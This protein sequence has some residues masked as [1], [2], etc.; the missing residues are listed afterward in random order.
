MLPLRLHD[1]VVWCNRRYCA[2]LDAKPAPAT[3]LSFCRDP[4]CPP[5]CPTFR[6][7]ADHRHK[8]NQRAMETKLGIER[9]R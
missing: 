7:A 3:L 9:M 6:Q 1:D 4:L 2:E 5:L 8:R